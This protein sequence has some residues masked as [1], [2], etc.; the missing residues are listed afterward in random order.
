VTSSTT[1]T[2]TSSSVSCR[3]LETISCYIVRI[4]AACYGTINWHAVLI[5]TAYDGLLLHGI[6][7]PLH[8]FSLGFIW[9]HAN[10]R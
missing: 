5:S 2:S 3:I 7:S 10:C 1:T 4:S 6:S 9:M 8:V